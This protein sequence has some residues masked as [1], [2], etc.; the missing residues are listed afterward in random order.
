MYTSHHMTAQT[1]QRIAAAYGYQADVV[2]PMQSGY[3]NQSWHVSC[4]QTELNIIIFKNEPGMQQ[5]IRRAD[6]AAQAAA[7]AGL[8]VRV[9]LDSR[10][11][12]LHSGQRQQLAGVYNYLPGSTIP[13]EGYTAKHIKQLGRTMAQLH[14]A[15]QPLPAADYPDVS[16]EYAQLLGRM[17]D[18]F[19]DKSVQAAMANK[20]GVQISGQLLQRY[21]VLTQKSG[22]LANQQVL[23]MDMVRSNV[24]FD[25]PPNSPTISGIIDFEKVAYGNP[26]F[27]IARTLAFLLV[28]CHYKTASEIR[29]YFLNSGY[30]RRGGGHVPAIGVE[31]GSQKVAL[32]ELLINLN[33]LHDFYK[34]LRHTPYESLAHNQH[35]CR[36]RG[37][38]LQRGLLLAVDEIT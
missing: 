26:L 5:R 21:C 19:N 27:D 2:H 7:A 8:P 16:H 35:Y 17:L 12:L 9:P 15:L 34:F 18:Y 28:D 11:L 32:L 20:L 33:L 6:R 37:I 23:H 38:L 10:L 4:G 24:L 31:W 3:R 30:T 14:H 29:K 1:I 13:W 25:G 36:T 22:Q